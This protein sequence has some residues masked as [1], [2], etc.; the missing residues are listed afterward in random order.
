[1]KL[2]DRA[3]EVQQEM[4]DIYDADAPDITG[5]TYAAMEAI[6]L[7]AFQEVRRETLEEAVRVVKS[8]RGD[9]GSATRRLTILCD[10]AA[11]NLPESTKV[12]EEPK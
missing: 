11:N 1:M 12:V 6:I 8:Q 2:E 10:M 5:K 3:D 4:R 7:K 9:M